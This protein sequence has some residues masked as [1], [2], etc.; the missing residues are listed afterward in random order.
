MQKNKHVQNCNCHIF[1]FQTNKL[2]SSPKNKTQNKSSR[3]AFPRDWDR[4]PGAPSPQAAPPAATGWKLLYNQKG[5]CLQALAAQMRQN[6]NVISPPE[7]TNKNP[8]RPSNQ[9]IYV[10]NSQRISL[11]TQSLVQFTHT[12]AFRLPFYKP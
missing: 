1:Y 10:I 2:L 9:S 7:N 3:T 11:R 4:G 5:S 8:P 6:R 12:E